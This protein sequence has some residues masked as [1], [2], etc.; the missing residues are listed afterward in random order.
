MKRIA[1]IIIKIFLGIILLILVMLF[2]I[3]IIFKKQIKSKVE[4]TIN[5]S[6]NARVK[7]TD[8]KLGF[9]RDFPNLSFSLEQMSVTGVGKFEGDTLAA[10]KSFDLVF[11]LMS[12]LLKSGYEVKSIII[13]KGNVNAIVLKNGLANWEISKPSASTAPVTSLTPASTPSPVSSSSS[14]SGSSIKILLRNFEIKNS[15]ITYSDSSLL[16]DARIEDLN[17]KLT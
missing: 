13:D 11:N 9:F 16:M 4:Q 3:P 14:T 8:Y 5:S 2:T 1:G 17:F 12:L 15:T 7:F 6:V 10:F